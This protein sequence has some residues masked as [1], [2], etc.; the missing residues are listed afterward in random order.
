MVAVAS[1]PIT[2][3]GNPSIS[4]VRVATAMR[5]SP[6]RHSDGGT[7]TIARLSCERRSVARAGHAA[8]AR[9]PGMSNA[10]TIAG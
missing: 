7:F 1:G 8:F 9:G 4:E 3:V 6:G 10:L 5:D 2:A